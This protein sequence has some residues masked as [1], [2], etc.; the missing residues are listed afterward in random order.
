[1]SDRTTLLKLI[2]Q[3]V[4]DDEGVAFVDRYNNR[5][6]FETTQDQVGV[7]SDLLV[8]IGERAGRLATTSGTNRYQARVSPQE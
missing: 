6:V 1:M 7:P 8:K 5:V 3:S 4:R 2:E